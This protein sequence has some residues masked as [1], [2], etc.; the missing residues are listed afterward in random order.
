[1]IIIY[2][3]GDYVEVE[4]NSEAGILASS[5]I[6]LIRKLPGDM[7]EAVTRYSWKHVEGINGIVH[8]KYLS[9]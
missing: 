7:W 9:R 2:E 5:D 3:P 6:E 8:E 1:M 4:D